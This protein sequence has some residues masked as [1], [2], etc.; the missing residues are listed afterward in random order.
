MRVV[1]LSDRDALKLSSRALSEGKLVVAPTDTIYGILADAT[2]ERAVNYLRSIRRHTPKPF[3]ILIPNL[4]W[5]KRLNLEADEKAYK[6]LTLERTTLVLK[7][8]TKI[9]LYLT[10][11]RDTLAV[12]LPKRGFVKELLVSFGKPLVAPSVNP[13]GGTPAL[14][15]DEAVKYFGNKVSLYVDAGKLTGLPSTIV[16]LAEGKPKVLRG[17][18][19]TP[20]GKDLDD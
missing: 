18:L 13:E 11:G 14:S 15:I 5:I 17:R 6:L 16:S 1:K 9:P 8:K 3:I 20:F 4:L 7:R 19:R 2:Q 12:R 10:L